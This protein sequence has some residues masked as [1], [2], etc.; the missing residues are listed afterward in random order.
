MSQAQKIQVSDVELT[1]KPLVE[2]ETDYAFK[3]L[4]GDGQAVASDLVQ[5]IKEL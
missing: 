3:M 4:Y 5:S 1:K 2:L